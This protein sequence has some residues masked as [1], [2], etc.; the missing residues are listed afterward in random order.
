MED[1][2]KKTQ[3]SGRHCAEVEELM[4]GKLPFVTRHGVTAV[5][6]ALA[7][8]MAL[9]FMMDGDAGELIRGMVENIMQGIS[10]RTEIPGGS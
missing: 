4:E 3:D 9:L 7:I 10:A 2:G 1:S 5:I 6:A 8:V